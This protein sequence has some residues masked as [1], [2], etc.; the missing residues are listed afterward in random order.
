NTVSEWGWC[1]L[2]EQHASDAAE[3]RKAFNE[4]VEAIRR[5]LPFTGFSVRDIL[6]AFLNDL[7]RSDFGRTERYA[8]VGPL[9][10]EIGA[11]N[12]LNHGG[13]NL[14]AVANFLT[15]IDRKNAAASLI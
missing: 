2:R 12:P 13:Y 7:P 9:F 5:M 1:L 11:P 6:G 8:W 15:A 3:A 10:G 14:E 4:A